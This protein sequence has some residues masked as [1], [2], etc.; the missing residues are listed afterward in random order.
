VQRG[1]T[2]ISTAFDSAQ[3]KQQLLQRDF[4]QMT[5][6]CTALENGSD[7]LRRAGEALRTKLHA[8]EVRC[9]LFVCDVTRVCLT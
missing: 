1:S 7:E 8:A 5:V 2:T 6:H 3:D 4:A 9:D